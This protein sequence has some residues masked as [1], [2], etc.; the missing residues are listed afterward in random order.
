MVSPTGGC[1]WSVDPHSGDDFAEDFADKLPLGRKRLSNAEKS[2][3][4][5]KKKKK[6]K[7]KKKKKKKKQKKEKKKKKKKRKQKVEN[8][9]RKNRTEK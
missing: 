3:E 1:I 9:S 7:K 4:K 2:L 5:K 6:E 8:D